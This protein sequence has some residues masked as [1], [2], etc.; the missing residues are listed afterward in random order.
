MEEA[1]QTVPKWEK[2]PNYNVYDKKYF[3]TFNECDI[4]RDISPHL[5]SKFFNR[6]PST[7]GS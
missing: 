3:H 4:V 5:T 6:I 2:T 7:K 1:A